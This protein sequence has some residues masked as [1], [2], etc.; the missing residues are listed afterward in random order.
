V[1]AG[2]R[3]GNPISRAN[4]HQIKLRGFRI[5]LGEIEAA[6]DRSICDTPEFWSLPAKTKRA[7]RGWWHTLCRIRGS[8]DSRKSAASSQGVPPEYMV[9]SSVVILDAFPL[10]TPNGKIDWEGVCPPDDYMVESKKYVAP[11]D[12]TELALAQIWERSSGQAHRRWHD[13]FFQL[14]GIPCLRSLIVE[15]EKLYRKPVAT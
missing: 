7:R 1:P 15:I 14:G 8:A 11:R 9:P 4:G 3:M 10:L 13:N 5:E 12:I 6:L 2:C